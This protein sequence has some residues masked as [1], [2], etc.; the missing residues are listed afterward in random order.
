MPPASGGEARGG[1]AD[2]P[3]QV[4]REDPAEVPLALSAAT[5]PITM[6]AA[7]IASS[8][9][10]SAGGASWNSSVKIRISA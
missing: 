10:N 7:D 5:S 3:D 8:S 9:V 6:V 2:V 4:E 1:V